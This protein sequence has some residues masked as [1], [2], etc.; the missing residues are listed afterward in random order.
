MRKRALAAILTVC[1]GLP[2]APA[3]AEPDRG[4][5]C[6]AD[7]TLAKLHNYLMAGDYRRALELSQRGIDEAPS[8]AGYIRLTYVYRAIEAY[9]MHLTQ[10]E[11]WTAVEHLHLNLAYRETEDLIDPPGGLA[12]MAKEMIQESVRQQSDVSAAM[13]ARL[14]KDESDRLWAQ[15][16]D[17]R[18]RYPDSWWRGLPLDW[19]S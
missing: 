13:A 2:T 8:A 15:Q 18:A 16:T 19:R 5:F 7:R 11:Q 12:R 4:D 14:D 3:L 1:I 9:L 6:R 10:E 17:W